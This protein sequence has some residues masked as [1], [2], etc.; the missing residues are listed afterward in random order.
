MDHK[1]A[2]HILD[3]PVWNSLQTRWAHL[4]QH[5]D[6]VV[7]LNP[8]Y[9]PF[10]GIP[11]VS[12]TSV[13]GLNR[14]TSATG[15]VWLVEADPAIA[16]LPSVQPIRQAELVQMV[17]SDIRGESK[18][19]EIVPLTEA[20]AHEMIALADLTKPGPFARHTNRLAEFVG[21]KE[22][23]RLIAMC[24]ERM[25]LPGYSEL[26]GLC[27]HP[28]YQGRGLGGALMRHIARRILGR[29]DDVFLHAYVSNHGAIAL[30]ES[31]GF[32]IRTSVTVAIYDK[33]S[34]AV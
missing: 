33:S 4:A 19:T 26:S 2:G 21:V 31:L 32:A 10:A 17:A 25:K 13:G 30:Y 7:R 8:D 15:E 16:L 27:T 1:L 28:D 20:D 9:G 29:D 23:G 14:I 5:D 22:D 24:G 34:F 18:P 12:E 3:R 6:G 11:D